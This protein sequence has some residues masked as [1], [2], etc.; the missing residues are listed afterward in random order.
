MKGEGVGTRDMLYFMYWYL[1][2]NYFCMAKFVCFYSFVYIKKTF[3]TR[4]KRLSKFSGKDENVLS[5]G[6]FV[7]TCFSTQI[8][9]NRNR[10][11]K[12]NLKLT[13]ASKRF[14]LFRPLA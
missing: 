2:M 11:K 8:L 10:T 6:V 5:G 12:S 4:V 1:D 14:A 9:H 13:S 3:L 7:K